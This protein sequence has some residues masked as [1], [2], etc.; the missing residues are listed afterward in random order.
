MKLYKKYFSGKHWLA[1]LRRRPKHM[2]HVYAVIFSA[3]I[4]AILAAI[5]LYH[6]YGFWHERYSRNDTEVHGEVVEQSIP[7]KSP[8]E[9]MKDFLQEASTRMKSIDT[10]VIQGKE[11]YIKESTTTE[12]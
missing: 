9:I 11:V 4:T 6:D 12:N 2:Q 5:I 8:G 7:S 10:D 1:V 3:S